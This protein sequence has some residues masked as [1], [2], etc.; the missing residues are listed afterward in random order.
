MVYGL[1]LLVG[2][3]FG[4]GFVWL[5]YS[6][7]MNKII[8]GLRQEIEAAM[9][10]NA[11]LEG[12]I[13]EKKGQIE[14]LRDEKSTLQQEIISLKDDVAQKNIEIAVLNQQLIDQKVA[15]N[16]KLGM[17]NDTQGRLSQA[18][19][20]LSQTAMHCDNEEFV[21]AMKANL[22]QF[23]QDVIKDIAKWQ[24]REVEEDVV[25]TEP[26]VNVQTEE[27]DLQD[28]TL[29]ELVAVDD[30][31]QQEVASEP[32]EDIDVA[33]ESNDADDEINID[34]QLA[35]AE[36]EIESLGKQLD[37]EIAAEITEPAIEEDKPEDVEAVYT[38]DTVPALK[39]ES[40][41]ADSESPVLL[42][43]DDPQEVK[44]KLM[45]ESDEIQI[46]KEAG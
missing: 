13:T 41:E 9:V 32:V 35:E 40:N 15:S 45:G 16:D 23:Q 2:A 39:F 30:E 5:L 43:A 19:M 10:S 6:S 46:R 7:K 36:E 11:N 27:T 8:A 18:M 1:Y 37:E 29:E 25:E 14:V 34:V 38:E 42:A 31:Q 33:V 24:G 26:V 4:G 20:E 17:I 44:K 12:V 21:E 28:E 22:D 3:V